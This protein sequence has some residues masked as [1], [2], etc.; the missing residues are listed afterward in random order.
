[1][2]ISLELETSAAVMGPLHLY[3]LTVAQQL[4]ELELGNNSVCYLG[5]PQHQPA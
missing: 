5:Q 3:S 1:M 4:S 2:M